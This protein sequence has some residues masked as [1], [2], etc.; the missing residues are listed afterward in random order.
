M[1]PICRYDKLGLHD[2]DILYPHYYGCQLRK[3]RMSNSGD[4][5]HRT[6]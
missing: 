3:V 5:L 4:E 2:T 6:V 1:S